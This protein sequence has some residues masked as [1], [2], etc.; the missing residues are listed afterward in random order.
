MN[1]SE[2]TYM[3]PLYE[4][5]ELDAR[6][7]AEFELHLQQCL[8]CAR[9][10]EQLR[11]LDDVLRNAFA[12]QQEDSQ[13]LRARFW[14]QFSHVARFRRVLFKQSVKLKAIAAM[15]LVGTIAGLSYFVEQ[16]TTQTIY[17][18]AADD[19]DEE[20]VRR[21]PVEGWFNTPVE[22]ERLA[23]TQLGD[24]DI[25]FKFRP[26][27]YHLSRARVCD[28]LGKLYVHLVYQNGSREISV[29]LRRKDSEL[30][31]VIV[32]TVK[33][34]GLHAESTGRLEVVGFQSVKF[35]VL[36]VSDL[37]REE[38]LRL[39]REAADCFA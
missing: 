4:S 23:S 34:C 7:M 11:A 25:I 6:G 28:L 36:M 5:S 16:H 13:A 30:P 32:E 14:Q 39:A 35:T 38:N 31:G 24:S 12:E 8:S 10:V 27:D 2:A 19:H 9:E 3:M 29:F 18:S 20:V 17:A 21:V 26:S 1:C 37:F 22:I 15:L 33:G